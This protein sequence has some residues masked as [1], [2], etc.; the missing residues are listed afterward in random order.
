MHGTPYTPSET[1]AAAANALSG[2]PCVCNAVLLKGDFGFPVP[3]TYFALRSAAITGA[4][5]PMPFI[6]R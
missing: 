6:E 3:S 2:S 5:T 4:S 1:A